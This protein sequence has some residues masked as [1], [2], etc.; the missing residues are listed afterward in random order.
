MS[1][2]GGATDDGAAGDCVDDADGAGAAVED[3]VG[4][5]DETTACS[6]FSAAARL[7]INI[8]S[9]LDGGLHVVAGSAM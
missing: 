7:A 5:S 6:F 2:D 1:V 9:M 3:T 8:A 4:V